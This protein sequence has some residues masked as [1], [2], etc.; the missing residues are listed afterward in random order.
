MKKDTALVTGGSRGIGK[1]I[2]NSLRDTGYTV[3]CPGREELDLSSNTSIEKFCKDFDQP[4]NALVNNAGINII[5]SFEE[6][7][8]EEIDQ[9]FQVN[10]YSTMLLTKGLLKNFEK[11]VTGRMVNISSIW[12]AVAKE[13]R[14]IYAA[15]KS[16]INSLTRS[17]A[18]ELSPY[19][20]LVNAVAPGYT[21]TELTYKNNS[22]NAIKNIEKLIPLGRLADPGEIASV[23]KFLLSAENTYMTGQTIIVDGGYTIQ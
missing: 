8:S 22:E 18:L 10:L 2:V 4:L 20:I 13:K 16:A 12:S 15:T 7:S 11:G 19:N 6:V 5:N 14:A 21:A 17:L 9:T 23:V 1:A 3:Y